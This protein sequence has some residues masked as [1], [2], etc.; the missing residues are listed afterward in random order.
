MSLSFAPQDRPYLPRGVRLHEDHVRAQMV[1]LAP[2]KAIELD[3]IG[4]AILTRVTGQATFAQIIQ[5]L[6]STYN[7]PVDQIEDDVQRFL[8]QLRARLYIMVQR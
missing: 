7:A 6:A 5:D 8:V 3:E 2:E 1:L 4:V